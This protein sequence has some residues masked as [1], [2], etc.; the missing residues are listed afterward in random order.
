MLCSPVSYLRFLDTERT[1]EEIRLQNH[2]IG[3]NSRSL[4]LAVPSHLP[5]RHPSHVSARDTSA[6]RHYLPDSSI[7]K[8]LPTRN[9][10]PIFS[11][12]LWF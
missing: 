2:M 6:Y 11:L 12:P 9:V 7:N 5:S 8:P 3:Q 1:F 10:Q 4:P